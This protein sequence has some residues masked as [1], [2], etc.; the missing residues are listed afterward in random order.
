MDP[1]EHLD[2]L[3]P[4]EP[5]PVTNLGRHEAGG[6]RL[7]VYGIAHRRPRPRPELVAAA[8]RL[9][10]SVLPRPAL[11]GGR[12]GVGFL[13]IHDGRGACFVFVDWWADENELHH[14]VFIAPGDR[15]IDLVDHTASGPAACVWDLAVLAHERQAWVD[16]VLANPTGPDVEAYLD[17]ILEGHV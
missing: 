15:P 17:R 8:R 2:Q 14:R 16:T 4:Y 7:K 1:N 5:R 3:E 13:G 6:W 10:R 11:G 12:H 9:A